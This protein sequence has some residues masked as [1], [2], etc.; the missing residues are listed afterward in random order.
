M[1][2]KIKGKLIE[3]KKDN[4]VLILTIDECK[5]IMDKLPE[6]IDKIV[7]NFTINE[8]EEYYHIKRIK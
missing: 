1:E 2:V 8:F 7:A 4:V 3:I 5:K 6:Q